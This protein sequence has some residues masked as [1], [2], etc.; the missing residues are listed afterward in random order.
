MK[1]QKVIKKFKKHDNNHPKKIQI[2]YTLKRADQYSDILIKDQNLNIRPVLC[3]K[4][5]A[6]LIPLS[7][8]LY[9]IDLHAS[10]LK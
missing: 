1:N 5:K 9:F 10:N 2:I 4:S 6:S 8:K 7:L 3:T